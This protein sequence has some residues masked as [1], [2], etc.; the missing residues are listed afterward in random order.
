MNVLVN[1]DG[2]LS[3]HPGPAAAV[4]RDA[5]ETAR[6]E[7]QRAAE[8]DRAGGPDVHA[9]GPVL[10]HPWPNR[11]DITAIDGWLPD[12]ETAEDTPTDPPFD[13]PTGGLGCL[14]FELHPHFDC[15]RVDCPTCLTAA[16]HHRDWQRQRKLENW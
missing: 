6:R 2:C 16:Q 15:R 11:P 3:E 9:R 7:A 1:I 8:T 14:D 5:H 4:D 12:V 10:R 13:H